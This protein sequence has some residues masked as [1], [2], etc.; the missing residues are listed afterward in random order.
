MVGADV[1]ELLQG[2]G[3]DDPHL[4]G[5]LAIRIDA[6]TVDR[7]GPVVGGDQ[8]QAAGLQHPRHLAR[9]GREGDVVLDHRNAGDGLEEGVLVAG[10]GQVLDA[11]LDRQGLVDVL[12]GPLD[13]AGVDVLVVELA[14][15]AWR[16]HARARPRVQH[17]REPVEPVGQ[18]PHI[19]DGLEGVPVLLGVV[20][21]GQAEA[22]DEGRGGVGLQSRLQG[23]AFQQA[24]GVVDDR[25]GQRRTVGALIEGHIVFLLSRSV[26][27]PRQLSARS[28]KGQRRSVT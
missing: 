24:G 19:G 4:A 5:F 27:F 28:P 21:A 17:R 14:Q 3:V 26:W 15:P 18:G 10:A 7:L 13:V 12:L 23:A 1:G 11:E 8:Q 9:E 2:L 25:G 6:R 20:V 16:H 22:L